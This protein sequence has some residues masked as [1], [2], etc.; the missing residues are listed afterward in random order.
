[1]PVRRSVPPGLGGVLVPRRL[2][3]GLAPRAETLGAVRSRRSAQVVDLGGDRP[4]VGV[5]RPVP[6]QMGERG[7]DAAGH[8]GRQLEERDLGAP[9]HTV[10]L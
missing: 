3:R 2:L 5:I 10:G 9:P 7:K 4:P 8:E 1:M 6:G